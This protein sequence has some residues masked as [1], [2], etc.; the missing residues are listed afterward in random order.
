M[1]ELPDERS[2]ALQLT[3]ARRTAPDVRLQ[4]RRPESDLAV[5]QQVDLFRQQVSFH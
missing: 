4:R 5:Q 1:L 3:A 2:R